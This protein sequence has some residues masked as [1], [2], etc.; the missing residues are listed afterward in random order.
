MH[1]GLRTSRKCIFFAIPVMP[2][3]PRLY[4]SHISPDICLHNTLC[5]FC[6]TYLLGRVTMT[7]GEV[8][9]GCRNFQGVRVFNHGCIVFCV[10]GTFF[11]NF[12]KNTTLCLPTFCGSGNIHVCTVFY[13]HLTGRPPRG[14]KLRP[15]PQGEIYQEDLRGPAIIKMDSTWL[16]INLC[17]TSQ[18]FEISE[19]PYF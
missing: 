19:K 15:G 2:E 9:L 1:S 17:K 6:L 16:R 14:S 18:F 5:A 13:M 7:R 3:C 8:L 4:N 10:K 12:Q 11:Q